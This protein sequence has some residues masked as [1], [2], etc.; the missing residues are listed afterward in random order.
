MIITYIRRRNFRKN[1]YLKHA[2]FRD[3]IRVEGE[4]ILL[5]GIMQNKT[6]CRIRD[7]ESA[8]A[9]IISDRA[10][11]RCNGGSISIFRLSDTG[12][13]RLQ[14]AAS[15]D[16]NRHSCRYATVRT[17]TIFREVVLP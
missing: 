4:V 6:F 13:S 11:R 9:A 16:C 17:E 15:R 2:K 3:I 1:I 5:R 7:D 14:L 12:C 8:D 10:A